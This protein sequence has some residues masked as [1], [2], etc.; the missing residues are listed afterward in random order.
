MVSTKTGSAGV[1]SAVTASARAGGRS[2]DT[3]GRLSST[4]AAGIVDKAEQCGQ[5]KPCPYE[6][7]AAQ[8]EGDRRA[9]HRLPLAADGPGDHEDGGQRRGGVGDLPRIAQ[10]AGGQQ[11]GGEDDPPPRAGVSQRQQRHDEQDRWPL[12]QRA[13]VAVAQPGQE[14]REEHEDQPGEEGDCA[15]ETALSRPFTP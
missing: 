13:G 2:E 14:W 5:G 11:Q 6:K 8:D 3:S 12:N 7:H 9:A 1:I 10:V 4:G 15:P